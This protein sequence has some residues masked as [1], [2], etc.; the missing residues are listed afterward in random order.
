MPHPTLHKTL[1]QR[2]LLF[3]FS[4]FLFLSSVLSVR[5]VTAV[6]LPC[7]WVRETSRLSLIEFRVSK[8]VCARNAHTIE[9]G[10]GDR[11]KRP[12]NMS[13]PWTRPTRPPT[14]AYHEKGKE[15]KL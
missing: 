8:S 10:A 12:N 9:R 14:D 13:R 15:K 2:Q 7:P 6:K 3:L 4:F 1:E 11:G 5:A